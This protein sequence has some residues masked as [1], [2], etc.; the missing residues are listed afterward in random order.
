MIYLHYTIDF[1]FE[2]AGPSPDG[3][4]RYC[5]AA[6]GPVGFVAEILFGAYAFHVGYGL[7]KCHHVFL[8]G[9]EGFQMR[10][11]IK[12]AEVQNGKHSFQIFS[13]EFRRFQMLLE[14][15]FLTLARL[16]CFYLV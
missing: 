11:M 2:C 4:S 12:I 13:L 16:G 9:N 5:F 1:F 14:Y 15:Y 7:A 10:P 6:A 8:I 3:I